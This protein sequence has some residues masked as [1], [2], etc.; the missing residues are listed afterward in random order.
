MSWPRR[1][2]PCARTTITP[3]SS[4]QVELGETTGAVFRQ[5]ERTNPAR[6]VFDSLSEIRLGARALRY[7]R[8]IWP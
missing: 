5:V 3:S 6:V 8:Q 4:L 7:R 1:R 2:N